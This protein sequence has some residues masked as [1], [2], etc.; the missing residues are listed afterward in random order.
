MVR[1]V[2]LAFVAFAGASGIALQASDSFDATV[3]RTYQGDGLKFQGIGV[4]E[5]R[6]DKVSCWNMDGAADPDLTKQV[7]DYYRTNANAE[8]SFRFGRKN[9]L[10][11]VAK[12]PSR[13]INVNYQS[14]GGNYAAMAGYSQNGLPFD[15]VNMAADASQSEVGI[16]VNLY[17]LPGPTPVVVPFKKGETATYGGV[18]IEVGAYTPVKPEEGTNPYGLPTSGKNCRVVLGTESQG[19]RVS[20][21]GYSYSA[22]DGQGKPIRYVDK[23][24]EP[25]SD[26]KVL[27]DASPATNPRFPGASPSSKYPS[28]HFQAGSPSTAGATSFYTNVNPARIGSLK[29]YA[30]SQKRI[31]INGF[32]LDPR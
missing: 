24:G 18:Q 28:A 10:L 3:S 23:N 1:N 22:L 30:S 16:V 15:L 32:P 25:V 14:V 2:L 4:C 6:P 17:G 8:I 5:V 27:E 12:Q 19:T 26:M 20:A 7:D 9:R 31:L 29:I 21:Y 13:E 11:V